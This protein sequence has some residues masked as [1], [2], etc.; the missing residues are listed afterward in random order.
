MRNHHGWVNRPGLS[1][2]E[3]MIVLAILG[4][5]TTLAGVAIQA[6]RESARQL[7]CLNNLREMG[8]GAQGY[9]AQHRMFPVG[10][11]DH[12]SQNAENGLEIRW[13]LSAQFHLLPYVDQQSIASSIYPKMKVDEANNTLRQTSVP[14]YRCPSETLLIPFSTSYLC[15]GGISASPVDALD[16]QRGVFSTNEVRTIPDGFSHTVVF[17]ERLIGTRIFGLP[18]TGKPPRDLPVTMD[19]TIPPSSIN[20]WTHHCAELEAPEF[21]VPCSGW[22]YWSHKDTFY[23]H[24][25]PPNSLGKDCLTLGG[26]HMGV[27]TARSFHRSGV[28]VAF[29]DGHVSTASQS[30]D[31]RVWRALAT[32][33]GHESNIEFDDQQ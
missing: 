13:Q 20:T 1:L 5:M 28:Q 12:Q 24:I 18:R 33:E 3:L 10:V 14:I 2:I 15:N 32:I 17:S 25:L 29:A 21:W 16:H 7:Q 6:T 27:K 8:L 22:E 11:A 31:Y 19:Q 23:N 26:P 4:A 9:Y 30:I